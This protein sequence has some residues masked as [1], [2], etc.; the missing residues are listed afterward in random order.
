MSHAA[1]DEPLD[2]ER[3][4]HGHRHGLVDRSIARSRA[5]VRAG[6]LALLVLIRDADAGA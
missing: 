3:H 6:L 1:N 2:G 4:W 5:G